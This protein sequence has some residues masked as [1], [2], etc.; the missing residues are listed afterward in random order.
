RR[1]LFR[2]VEADC[3]LDQI[4]AGDSGEGHPSGTI[5]A[6][7]RK[8]LDAV[9]GKAK[10]IGRLDWVQVIVLECEYDD[11]VDGLAAVEIDLHPVRIRI[12]RGV[13]PAA[14]AETP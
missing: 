3:A 13:R 12:G 14:A 8:I 11:A 10:A 9:L 2:S 1:V 4:V 7:H 5:P 6:L